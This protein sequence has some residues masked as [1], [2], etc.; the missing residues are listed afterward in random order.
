MTGRFRFLFKTVVKP[1]IA[2]AYLA[3]GRNEE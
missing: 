1:I 3:Q 2:L